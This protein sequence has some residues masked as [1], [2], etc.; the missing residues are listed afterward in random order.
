MKPFSLASKMAA[1][2]VFFS[3]IFMCKE[4]NGKFS[5]T[6]FFGSEMAEKEPK[7]LGQIVGNTSLTIMHK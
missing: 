5:F 1:V 6:K 3:R 4:S 7:I 2:P